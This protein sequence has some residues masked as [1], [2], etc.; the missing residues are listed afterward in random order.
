[1]TSGSRYDDA[2]ARYLN[3]HVALWSS[4]SQG[5][6]D[7]LLASFGGAPVRLSSFRG[8]QNVVLV[9]YRGHW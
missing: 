9:F 5:R 2:K 8:K 1:L 3:D 4:M 6:C 7:F